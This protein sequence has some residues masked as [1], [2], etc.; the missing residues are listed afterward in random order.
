MAT[1]SPDPSGPSDPSNALPRATRLGEF[2]ML[3]VLG[4]G[5]FGIVY[6]AFDHALEREVAVK[7]YMPSSLAGRSSAMQV[8]VIS[9]SHAEP[10]ALG[11]RSFVNEARLLARFDHPALVKVYR[12]W[13]ANGTAYMA[14]PFYAG[15]NLHLIRQDMTSP[16]DET[17]LRS[18]LEPLLGA[19]ERLHGEGVY[20][21][22][23]SPDN[24][25]VLADGQPVLLDFGAAR[26]VITDKSVA[27]TAILKPAYAP[28]EQYGE[29]GPVRQGPWTDLYALGATMHFLLL[30]RAP[31]PS[32][33]RT[34]HDEVVPLS[35]RAL[36]GCGTAFLACLD[37]MLR[38]MPA[39]RPQSVA[40]LR[41]G[42][43]GRRAA[44]PLPARAAPDG[45]ADIELDVGAPSP[46]LLQPLPTQR[47]DAPVQRT[48]VQARHAAPAAS[49]GQA[50]APVSGAAS[51]NPPAPLA[52]IPTTQVMPGRSGSPAADV[53][54]ELVLPVQ[55]TRVEP[56][57]D[58]SQS[59]AAL[60][61]AA[62][63]RP[64]LQATSGPGRWPLVAGLAAAAAAAAAWFALK[65]PAPVPVAPT[66]VLAA[67]APADLGA[68]SATTPGAAS[69]AQM[70]SLAGATASAAATSMSAAASAPAV[71]A[72]PTPAVVAPVAPN[73]VV[74]K[75]PTLVGG[76]KPAAAAASRP[77]TK[78]E[79]RAAD[80]AA[81]L[82]EA[83][84]AAEQAAA[85]AAAAAP[86]PG[87][88]MAT[89]ITRLPPAAESALKTTPA[90]GLA[91]DGRAAVPGPAAANP[92]PAQAT[93]S[94]SGTAP[95]AAPT[96]QP[97]AAAV[98]R[99]AE[100]EAEQ[101]VV[102]S[103]VLGPSDR[104]EGRSAILLAACIERQCRSAPEL[105]NH[106]ECSKF[107]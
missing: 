81:R 92:T 4:V 37:W 7:E 58:K 71:L 60:G 30:A 107:R 96:V 2:E 90:P 87:G 35:S 79:Q 14:M 74:S 39:Q 86:A 55:V 67:S 15:K 36:P 54:L 98:T 17:W 104:C 47:V 11:L 19:L 49:A 8:S 32:I 44:P 105:Q 69:A 76:A 40:E 41:D 66:P 65:G 10:F 82:A 16:P 20:H 57:M 72:A 23:I 93:P 106:P 27:L 43:A 84:A 13:E 50:A 63:P 34:V 26:R 9:Q 56:G 29:A 75:A 48:E 52:P 103:R 99:P 1:N 94:G 38:P 6:L 80:K 3:R 46:T 83:K 33:S 77:L 78:A 25:I 21:R 101:P 59:G 51:A 70:P 42:L 61:E 88:G 68:A 100:R 95:Q 53:D 5:G 28:I 22:D 12:Y 18:I 91:S 97:S 89:S 85:P 31:Q 24:V 45:D 102:R 64:K 73:V 62:G